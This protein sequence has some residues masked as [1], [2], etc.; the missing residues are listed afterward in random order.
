M[1]WQA[2]L[3]VAKLQEMAA[4]IAWQLPVCKS[5]SQCAAWIVQDHY[6]AIE[7]G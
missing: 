5:E 1:Q 3:L 2:I 4:E 7:H 6:T